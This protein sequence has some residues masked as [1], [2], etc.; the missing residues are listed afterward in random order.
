MS[1]RTS[2]SSSTTRIFLAGMVDSTL[3]PLARS[4]CA[5]GSADL[6]HLVRDAQTRDLPARLVGLGPR[7]EVAVA[8]AH[9]AR[10]GRLGGDAGV[11]ARAAQLL[12]ELHRGPQRRGHAHP[13]RHPGPAHQEHALRVAVLLQALDRRL[14]LL[15]V[16]ERGDEDR[17]EL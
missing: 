12:G 13:Y 16:P 6:D 17:E 5:A 1:L 11:V 3:A 8:Q 10:A 9:L 15:R 14:P 7:G 4:S 2:G